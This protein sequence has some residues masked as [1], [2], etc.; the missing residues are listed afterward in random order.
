MI[1]NI[2]HGHKAV[3]NGS[4]YINEYDETG[5]AINV[6]SF[7]WEQNKVSQLQALQAFLEYE[8]EPA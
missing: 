5:R 6:F 8:M 2:G 4:H 7:A 1:I 3:W